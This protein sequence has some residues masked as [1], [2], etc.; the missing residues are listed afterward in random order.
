MYKINVLT[1][2][3]FNTAHTIVLLSHTQRHRNDTEY[4]Y[5]IISIKTELKRSISL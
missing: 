4:I 5:Y 3:I 1:K 2:V